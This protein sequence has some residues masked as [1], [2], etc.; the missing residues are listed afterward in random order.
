MPEA[1]PC[2]IQLLIDGR[3][4]TVPGG[5]TVAAALAIAGINAPRRS[6]GGERR[7]A[8]CG[9]GICHECR[10]TVDGTPHQRTCLVPCRDGMRV[11][12]DA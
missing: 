9:M 11:V 2:E 3:A 12:T 5:I 7:G 8:L 1:R 6:P 10:A 4:C